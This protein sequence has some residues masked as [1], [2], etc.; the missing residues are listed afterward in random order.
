MYLGENITL[1]EDPFMILMILLI[2]RIDAYATNTT[3]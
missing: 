1:F 2:F 3:G